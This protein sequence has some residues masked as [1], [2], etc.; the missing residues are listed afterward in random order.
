MRCAQAV[1]YRGPCVLGA[2]RT[3]PRAHVIDK[4]KSA[5]SGDRTLAQA[6]EPTPVTYPDSMSRRAFTPDDE[7]L[8]RE[9]VAK[10]RPD[11]LPLLEE[12]ATGLVLTVSEANKLQ[13]AVADEFGA[14]PLDELGGLTAAGIR[15]DHL[16]DSVARASHIYKH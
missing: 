16:I 4:E 14:T 15:L 3:V 12:A 8:L 10:H 5:Q 1:Q 11:L 13:D 7:A 9:V 2:R 6:T